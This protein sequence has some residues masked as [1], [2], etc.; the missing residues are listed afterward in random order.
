MRRAFAPNGTILRNLNEYSDYAIEAATKSHATLI[1][2][3][4]LSA[5]KLER[6]GPNRALQYALGNSTSHVNHKGCKE[7][8]KEW[9]Q[10]FREA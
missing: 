1:D 9:A 5:R 2:L 8:A 7:Y 6:W 3:H 4:K 10:L